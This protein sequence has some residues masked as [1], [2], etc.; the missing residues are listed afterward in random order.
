MFRPYK[1]GVWIWVIPLVDINSSRSNDCQPSGDVIQVFCYQ[2]QSEIG[3]DL[4]LQQKL[5]AWQN[6]K[7]TN[8]AA[9]KHM[10]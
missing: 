4:W 9:N 10:T 5:R 8:H 6:K 2:R 1:S 3:G 7:L